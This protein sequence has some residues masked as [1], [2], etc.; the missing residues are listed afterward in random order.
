MSFGLARENDDISHAIEEA[1][2]NGAIMFAAASNYG[3]NTGIAFPARSE[4]VLCI[5][6]SDGNGNKSGM[7]PS[8]RM[9]R[10]NFSTLG[11][12][13]PSVTE[14]GIYLSG[15]SYSTPVAVGIAANILRLVQNLA[16]TNKLAENQ[17]M[18]AFSRTGMKNILLTMSNKRD[19]Y[20]Y[21]APWWG[22][23]NN[24]STKEQIAWKIEEAL[25]RDMY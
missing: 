9:G 10:E 22:M 14:K 5:H 17:L 16:D 19:G 15:T 4:K 12:A 2:Y 3:G 21:V 23:W 25:D 13:I 24:V 11:V 6:A 1:E 8:P 7:D 20:H 18:R